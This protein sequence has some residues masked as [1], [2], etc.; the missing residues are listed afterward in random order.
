MDVPVNLKNYDEFIETLTCRPVKSGKVLLYGS[1]F[2]T[3]WGYERAQDQLS[4]ATGGKLDIVNHGFGGATIDELLYYYDRLVKPYAP[5]V[6]VTRT[7]YND[8]GNNLSPEEALFLTQRL[9]RWLK[10]DFPEVKIFLLPV[11]DAKIM[12]PERYADFRRY[13]KLLTDYTANIENVEIFDINPFF[14]EKSE[15]IGDLSKLRDVFVSDGLHLTDEAYVEMAK[16]F[17]PRLLAAI[18]K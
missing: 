7:G 16:F 5:S 12:T 15:D 9:I 14:Y 2:F 8:I 4:A 6:V 18:N 1:S 13:N 11:F 3:R 10:A 17:G